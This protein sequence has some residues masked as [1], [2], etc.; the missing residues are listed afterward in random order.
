MGKY[1]KKNN[2]KGANESGFSMKNYNNNFDN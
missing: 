1:R 2:H